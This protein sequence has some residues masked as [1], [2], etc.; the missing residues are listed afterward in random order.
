LLVVIA[1][2]WF[3]APIIF[4][5]QPTLH[6]I[7]DDLTQFWNFCCASSQGKTEDSRSV[8]LEERLAANVNDPRANMYD[9]WLKAALDHKRSSFWKRLFELVGQIAILVLMLVSV[10]AM[11]LDRAE[12]VLMFILVNFFLM[13]LWQLLGMPSILM[14]VALSFWFIATMFILEEGIIKPGALLIAFIVVSRGMICL[15]QLI[16]L[17][18]WVVI[19]PNPTCG[20]MPEATLEQREAKERAVRCVYKYDKLVEYLYI[21]LMSYQWHLYVALVV[22]AANFSLQLCLALLE[23]LGGLHSA[24]LLNKRLMGGCFML[25]QS[26]FEPKSDPHHSGDTARLLELK[27]LAPCQADAKSPKV[28]S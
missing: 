6:S 16:L 26:G 19:R 15:E 4:C 1:V 5:P 14:M 24:L 22:L 10:Y 13:A 23:A 20:Q 11:M 27:K 2:L 17:F 25:Q 18:A 28:V 9:L 21:Y 8:N 12:T 3:I 7:R